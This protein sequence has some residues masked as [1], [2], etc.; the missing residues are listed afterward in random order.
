MDMTV[1]TVSYKVREGSVA[2]AGE[3]PVPQPVQV[4]GSYGLFE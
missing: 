2:D 4:A 3:P 1:L